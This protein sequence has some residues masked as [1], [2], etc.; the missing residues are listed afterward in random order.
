MTLLSQR[1][2]KVAP[3]LTLA[4]SAKAKELRAQGDDVI[5]FGAGEPD[6]DTP[7]F[8]KQ[9]T[10]TQL[11]NGFTRYT[12]AS[13]IPEL[14]KAIQ[15]KFKRENNLN[16]EL[17]E[18]IVSCGAKHSLYNLFQVLCDVG[19]EVL[20]PAPYWVS[21]LPQIEL[22]GAV[23]VI[24]DTQKND[25]FIDLKDLESKITS[26]TKIL[27]LNNP[28]NPT[29]VFYDK[30]FLEKLTQIILKHDLWVI[31]DEIYEHLIY[32]GQP[33]VSIANISDEIKAKTIVVNG[34]SKSYAMTGWRIGYLAGN[35]DVV[36]AVN[37]I[38]SHS[39]S[40]PVSFAQKGAV[41]ALNKGHEFTKELRNIFLKRR[42]LIYEKISVISGLTVQ[43]PEGA[44]YIFPDVSSFYGKS[45]EG[46]TIT[47]S[48]DF[49]NL[50]LEYEKVAVVPGVAF[51]ADNFIR[52]SYAVSE[53]EIAEGISR[54]EK[55]INKLK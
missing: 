14:K 49:S 30:A 36:S 24:L 45:Y 54:I 23:P 19:D 39:T 44:F 27:L 50:L 40:N 55:F 31:S 3:S 18:I 5:A 51:G 12:S 29:G 1:V 52:L 42:D 10:I 16:Y 20:L 41:V 22:A 8:I 43:K 9:E 21:Y 11:Q 53:K 34:V 26:K 33:Y 48:L 35:K 4:V 38:Q 37:K 15:A 17:N 46:K 7:D 32:T 13:G 47:G 2:Q 25:F 28:S 6:F